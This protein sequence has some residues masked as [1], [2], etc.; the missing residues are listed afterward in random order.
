MV[1]PT[2]KG[3]AAPIPFWEGRLPRV[4]IAS[5][6]ALLG[7]EALAV[8]AT[9]NTSHYYESQYD[10]ESAEVEYFGALLLHAA[11][12]EQF[13]EPVKPPHMDARNYQ[14]GYDPFRE[15]FLPLAKALYDLVVPSAY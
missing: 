11:A 4:P 9:Q 2:P 15:V 1:G 13:Q 5:G 6:G 10:T 3:W 7:C 8:G 14:A 12:P